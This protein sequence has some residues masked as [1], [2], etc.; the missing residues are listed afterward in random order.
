MTNLQDEF[1]VEFND[2]LEENRMFFESSLDEEFNPDNLFGGAYTVWI[3]QKDE[4]SIWYLY[5]PAYDKFYKLGKPVLDRKITVKYKLGDGE[6]DDDDCEIDIETKRFEYG[7]SC[8]VTRNEDMTD[9]KHAEDLKKAMKNIVVHKP[10]TIPS[11]TLSSSEKNGT[12]TVKSGDLKTA[13]KLHKM[14]YSKKAVTIKVKTSSKREAKSQIK[15]LQKNLGYV[16]KNGLKVGKDSEYRRVNA[17]QYYMVDDY[18]IENYL[19]RDKNNYT[20]KITKGAARDYIY[21]CKAFDRVWKWAL[22]KRYSMISKKRDVSFPKNVHLCDLS[23]VAKTAIA[24][25]VVS[26]SHG[27]EFECY[28]DPNFKQPYNNMWKSFVNGKLH[29]DFVCGEFAE[30]YKMVGHALGLNVSFHHN[31]DHAWA[32]FKVRDSRKKLQR[33][34]VDNFDLFYVPDINDITVPDELAIIYFF[35]G[36]WTETIS[37]IE[38]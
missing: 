37:T 7:I 38:Q 6:E 28:S 32:V 34:R 8:Y 1:C 21:S 26:Y 30:A 25:Y 12:L 4:N 16:N 11:V 35:F 36:S 27:Y 13:A 18:N 5:I 9:K 20:V 23:D 31:D 2:M 29:Y 17:S 14:L 15:K 33:Y 3:G 19:Y 22:D 10:V 24:T